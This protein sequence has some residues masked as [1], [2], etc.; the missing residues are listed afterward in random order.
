[1]PVSGVKLIAQLNC[2]YISMGNKQEKLETIVQ[3]ESCYAVA[4][5]ETKWGE[6]CKWS[7][8]IHG[9]KHFRRDK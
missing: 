6:A 2:I 5:K 3:Q 1:M 4:I 8:S 9:Y 7:A